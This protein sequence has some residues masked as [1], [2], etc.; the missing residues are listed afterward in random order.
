MILWVLQRGYYVG[1]TVAPRE[2]I[3]W[4]GIQQET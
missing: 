2:E 1:L 3:D 4:N